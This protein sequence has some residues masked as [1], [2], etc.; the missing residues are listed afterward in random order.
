[1]AVI[2]HSQALLVILNGSY[3]NRIHIDTGNCH[4]FRIQAAAL[5]DFFHLDDDP[6]AGVL[7]GL[8]HGGDVDGADLPVNGAVAVLVGVA[9]TQEHHIDG[10]RLVEQPL[11]ALDLD[12]L[13]QVLLGDI[14]EFAAAVA[15]VGKGVQAH[16]GDGADVVGRDVPVHVGDD[17][18]GQVIRLDLVA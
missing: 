10:E 12:D 14:V 15:G 2:G 16:V 18:L 7:A 9:G 11:L 13:H 17:A 4:Q 8:S 6:A 1:A 3:H 5:D